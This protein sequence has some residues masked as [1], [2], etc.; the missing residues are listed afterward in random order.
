M[1]HFRY[2]EAG[3]ALTM[4]YE[5][6]RL[7]AYQDSGGVWTIGYG[8]TGS[9]VKSGMQIGTLQAESY[10]RADLRRSIDAVNTLV[11]APVAQNHFD[12]LVDFCFNAGSGNL[13]HSTLLVLINK[14]DFTAAAEEFGRWVYVAGTLNRGLQRRRTAEKAMFCGTYRPNSIA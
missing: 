5:G 14:R 13:Q 1:Q 12:A 8:H 10:L 3:L 11:S 4:R 6:L 2:S 7:Q 9:D